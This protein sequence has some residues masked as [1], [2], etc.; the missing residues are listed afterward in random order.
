MEIQVLKRDYLA[1]LCTT[2]LF[3]FQGLIEK[4]A[5]K[6]HLG[7]GFIATLPLNENN[8]LF[9][10]IKRSNLIQAE[11]NGLFQMLN[12]LRLTK[13][14]FVDGNTREKM[15]LDPEVLFPFVFLSKQ[16]NLLLNGLAAPTILYK[17]NRHL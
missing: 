7:S 16:S 10:H 1:K 6:F 5:S 3:E 13:Y 8:R 14:F 11:K 9:T 15:H 2:I 17:V 12:F 4:A